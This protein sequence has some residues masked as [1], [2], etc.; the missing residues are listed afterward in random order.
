MDISSLIIYA[1]VLIVTGSAG[2]LALVWTIPQAIMK[3]SQ[4]HG[5]FATLGEEDHDDPDGGAGTRV[6]AKHVNGRRRQIDAV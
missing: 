3:R 4:P 6:P 2:T 5:R 1:I